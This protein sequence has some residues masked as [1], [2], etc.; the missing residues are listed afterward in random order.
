MLGLGHLRLSLA[1]ARGIVEHDPHSTALVLTGS[2]AAG[3]FALPVG[4]DIMKL[5]TSPLDAGSRWGSTVLRPAAGLSLP[6]DRIHALRGEITA[7]VVRE[8]RPDIAVVDYRPLGR[9]DE[10]I[11]TLRALRAE[12]ACTLALGLWDVDDDRAELARYWDEA[13]A[14]TVGE[15]YDLALVYG[16][17]E[18]DDLRVERLTAQG[19]P[20]YNT[21]L[22]APPPA[23]HGPPDLEPGYLLVI[24]GAGST[25]PSSWERSSRRYGLSRWGARPYSSPGR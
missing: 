6:A 20:V 11:D 8:L 25:A 12:R 21:G 14:R 3:G 18:P 2:P 15:L 13:L 1:V 19:L 4:V 24:A 17:S 7:T 10:L 9:G 16:P 22:V 23:A 5:P